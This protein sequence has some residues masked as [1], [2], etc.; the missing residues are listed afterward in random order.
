MN[1]MRIINSRSRA[2]KKASALYLRAMDSDVLLSFEDQSIVVD[3]F[4]EPDFYPEGIVARL[5]SGNKFVAVKRTGLSIIEFE[6]MKLHEYED[7]RT[8]FPDG[9]IP[10]SA[11]FHWN[12]WFSIC[13]SDD[14]IDYR[15]DY[16]IVFYSLSAAIDAA[17][18]EI[19]KEQ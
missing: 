13:S 2:P 7:M 11:E 18:E 6:G 12:A 3:P 8:S 16:D 14:G 19:I 15:S 9:V 17:I 1:N 10:E 5:N 4:D